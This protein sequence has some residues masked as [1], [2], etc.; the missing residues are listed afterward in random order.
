MSSELEKRLEEAYDEIPARLDR[1]LEADKARGGIIARDPQAVKRLETRLRTRITEDVLD[2][3]LPRAQARAVNLLAGSDEEDM[4]NPV[5]KKLTRRGVSRATREVVPE[6][7]RKTWGLPAVRTVVSPT[8]EAAITGDAVEAI[9]EM[10]RERGEVPEF[11][12]KTDAGSRRQLFDLAKTELGKKQDFNLS[13]EFAE[14]SGVSADQFNRTM[15]RELFDQVKQRAQDKDLTPEQFE[16]F[17]RSAEGLG[18]TG[19]MF[20]DTFKREG[21]TAAVGL[22]AT[23]PDPVDFDR[24]IDPDEEE[25][26]IKEGEA[27]LAQ[28]DAKEKANQPEVTPQ[29]AAAQKV[30]DAR[31]LEKQKAMQSDDYVLGSGSALR[32]S[33]RELGTRSGAMNRAGRRLLR[34]GAAGEAFKMFGAAEAQKLSEGSAIQ[35]P[36]QRKR[37]EAQQKR[38]AELMSGLQQMMD[39]YKEKRSNI[40]IAGSPTSNI[41]QSPRN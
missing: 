2:F 3:D 32:R 5:R 18:V 10:R 11:Y 41:Q 24:A 13:R 20:D 40:G 39:D 7:D 28:T 33:P 23:T 31:G 22:G 8:R 27:F 9:R 15:R 6:S 26:M 14:K 38:T 19:Q 12:G 30:M 37:L 36:E 25:E 17:R 21:V 35:T 16:G 29:A 4:I 34:K 1:L